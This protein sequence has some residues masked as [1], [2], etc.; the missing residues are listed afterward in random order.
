MTRIN[1]VPPEELCDQ[2]LRAEIRELPRVFPLAEKF[3]TN[4]GQM[5]ELPKEYSLGKGHVR[6]FYAHYHFLYSRF[7]DLLHEA[8]S[9]G[10]QQVYAQQVELGVSKWPL[11][12]TCASACLAQ[13]SRRAVMLNRQ[14]IGQRLREMKR[15]PKWTI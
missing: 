5:H 10:F 2:M 3:W 6:F 15:E 12:S 7:Y 9:R 13:W 11:F 4:G 8:H 14:R 1:L